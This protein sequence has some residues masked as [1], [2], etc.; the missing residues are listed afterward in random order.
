MLSCDWVTTSSKTKTFF[1]SYHHL[2]RFFF[3]SGEGR[4]P[5]VPL[6]FGSFL[7]ERFLHSL[8]VFVNHFLCNFSY[9]SQRLL[10]LD[11]VPTCINCTAFNHNGTLC[12]SGGADGMIRLFGESSHAMQRVTHV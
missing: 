12:I 11:P 7:F 4:E 10:P 2:F 3:H 1:L 5:S 8:L 9:F 6:P